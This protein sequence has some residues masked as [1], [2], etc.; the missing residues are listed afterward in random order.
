MNRLFYLFST[1]MLM[2]VAVLAVEPPR[3]FG[4]AAALSAAESYVPPM[5]LA[6]IVLRPQALIGYPTY[7]SPSMQRMPIEVAEAW[8]QEY[9]GMNPLSIAEIKVIVAMPTG[10]QPPQFGLVITTLEDF[11]PDKMDPSL[12]KASGP[13]MQQNRKIY[14][15]AIP[16]SPVD[17]VLEM[18]NARTALISDPL[19]LQSMRQSAQGAGPLAEL[20][21]KNPIGSAHGQIVFAAQPLRPFAQQIANNP[22][23]DVP[24]QFRELIEGVALINAVVVRMKFD[25]GTFVARA[26]VLADDAP[27]AT[28]LHRA[29]DSAIEFIKETM[30]DRIEQDM[31]SSEPGPVNDAFVSYLKR[32]I[33]EMVAS[34]RPKLSDDRVVLDFRA[35][36]SIATTGVLVGLLLPAVQASRQAARRMSSSNNLKQ[37]GLAMHNYH[38][39]FNHFPPAAI[40]NATGEPLLSWRVALLPFMEEMELYNQFKLDEP[41]NSEHNL[42]LMDKM[43]RVFSDPSLAIPPGIAGGLTNYHLSIGDRLLINPTGKSRFAQVTDGTSN[44]IMSIAGNE[45]S[46]RPWT[47]PDYPE[48]SLDDPLAYV[49]RANGF[50]VGFADGAVIRMSPEIDVETFK[51]MLTRDG[52]ETINR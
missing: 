19:M 36:N 8:G 4:Q 34:Y 11:N 51:A 10:P 17:M 30:L 46:L 22:P 18:V 13:V 25:N 20:M 43:P 32:I 15:L 49:I 14:P 33:D 42:L 52:R 47:S 27:S 39:T 37:I 9:L 41:W 50:E 26:E 21:K 1:G 44:T 31:S 23:S 48:I 45:E 12:L 6:A 40:T 38:A 7:P 2:I 29:A 3:A 5:G 24:P 28:K 16:D 35:D